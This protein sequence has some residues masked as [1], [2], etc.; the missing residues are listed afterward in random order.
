MDEVPGVRNKCL[1]RVVAVYASVCACCANGIA[2][3][4]TVQLRRQDSKNG[5]VNAALE[6]HISLAGFIKESLCAGHQL[7]AFA[8]SPLPML[9]QPCVV[10]TIQH[11]SVLLANAG[12]EGRGLGAATVELS[13]LRHDAQLP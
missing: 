4:Y 2:H 12:Q 5:R 11:V 6:E 13:K 9:S 8:C 7:R 10:L 3:C 1:C